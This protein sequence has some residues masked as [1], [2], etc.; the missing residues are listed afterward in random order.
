MHLIIDSITSSR[1]LHSIGIWGCDI[2][3]TILCL[4]LELVGRVGN[5]IIG[6][7]SSKSVCKL[8]AGCDDGR[9]HGTRALHTG[10]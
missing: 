4:N 1:C 5:G 8:V 3:H 6:I 10:W 2:A 9:N 7:G